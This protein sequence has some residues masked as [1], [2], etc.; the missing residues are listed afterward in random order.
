MAFGFVY[1]L[2]VQRRK[3]PT[4]AGCFDARSRLTSAHTNT[5]SLL[6]SY[7]GHK[8]KYIRAIFFESYCVQEKQVK[9]ENSRAK[10]PFSSIILQSD[11]L[12]QEAV[13]VPVNRFSNVNS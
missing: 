12:R 4:A 5:R 6:S 1:W 7:Y 2:Y 10:A 3:R 9:E 11:R 8:L 13:N